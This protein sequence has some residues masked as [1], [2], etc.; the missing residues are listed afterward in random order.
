MGRE[1]GALIRQARIQ[2]GYTQEALA[3]LV[4]VQ[5]SAVA[6]W[7][8]GRVTEIKRSN[9]IS[10]A[11]ALGIEDVLLVGNA[12]SDKKEKPTDED[13]GLSDEKREL[14]AR[15]QELSDDQIQLLLQVARSI[16]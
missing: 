15:I 12:Y 13:D 5:K 11:D 2:K 8:N 4:G 16:K 14:I 7:E 9:L 3:K 6:K 1:I 10:L